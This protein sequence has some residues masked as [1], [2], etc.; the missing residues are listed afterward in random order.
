M[1]ILKIRIF[2]R[3]QSCKYNSFF[4]MDAAIELFTELRIYCWIDIED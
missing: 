1:F 4:E 3:I 2:G